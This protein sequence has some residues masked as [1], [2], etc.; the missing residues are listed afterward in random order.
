MKKHHNGYKR[1]FT[2]YKINKSNKHVNVVQYYKN[3]KKYSL[4]DF[5]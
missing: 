1:N 2:K 3:N 5:F 4:S